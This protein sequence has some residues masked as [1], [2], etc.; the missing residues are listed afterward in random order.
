M[1]TTCAPAGPPHPQATRNDGGPQR[2]RS[3]ASSAQV[4]WLAPPC[5]HTRALP[6]PSRH[7]SRYFT[8]PLLDADQTQQ[9][10]LH[11]LEHELIVYWVANI[12]GAS[13]TL[14]TVAIYN[15]V[16]SQS[17][18]TLGENN[19]GLGEGCAVWG[20][21]VRGGMG[22]AGL[23]WTRGGPAGVGRARALCSPMRPPT[24]R[25]SKGPAGWT[26]LPAL[27]PRPHQP[28]RPST[29]GPTARGGPTHARPALSLPRTTPRSQGSCWLR[30]LE[31]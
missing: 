13:G 21:V 29:P 18:S 31:M 22:W 14:S 27:T 28:P 25:S 17:N 7:P 10:S 1:C 19:S 24:Q 11:L 2:S 30:G 15:G 3:A 9:G 4:G 5:S 12:T 23:G 16:P 6:S 20:A 8:A 26:Y